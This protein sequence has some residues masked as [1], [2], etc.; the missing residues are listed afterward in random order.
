LY[1]KGATLHFYGLTVQ[2]IQARS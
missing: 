2:A 1:V